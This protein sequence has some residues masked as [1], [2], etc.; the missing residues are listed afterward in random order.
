M[1]RHIH[2]LF[3]LDFNRQ[4]KKIGLTVSQIEIL[5]FLEKTEKKEVH[6][7]DI[8]QFLNLKNPTVTGLLQRMEEKGFIEITVS[9]TDKRARCVISTQKAM[10]NK[11]AM[12]RHHQEME[13]ILVQ[14]MTKEEI[15]E[16]RRLLQ[17]VW[18]NLQTCNKD[19]LE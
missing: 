2:N 12:K 18:R 7:K 4:L 9:K 6:Q 3:E 15:H 1:F 16:L 8:E 13:R 11:K 17:M 19:E 10:D 5:R 14:G